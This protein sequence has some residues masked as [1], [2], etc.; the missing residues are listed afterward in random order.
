M[1]PEQILLMTDM[2]MANDD[3][4]EEEEQDGLINGFFDKS[5]PAVHDA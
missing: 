3:A 1:V 4:D 5:T 2:M